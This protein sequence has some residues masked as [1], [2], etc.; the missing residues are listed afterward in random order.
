MNRDKILFVLHAYIHTCIPTS[1]NQQTN[2]CT[3]FAHDSIYRSVASVTSG[4]RERPGGRGLYQSLVL[5]QSYS[6]RSQYSHFSTSTCSLLLPLPSPFHC[7]LTWPRG[8]L[9]TSMVYICLLPQ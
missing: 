3:L 6:Y 4:R 5:L 7:L 1:G 9:D 8:Q 2:I